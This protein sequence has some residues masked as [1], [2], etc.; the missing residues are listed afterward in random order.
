MAIDIPVLVDLLP[1]GVMAVD[2]GMRI[3][4]VNE[5]ACRLAHCKRGDLLGERC[6]DRLQP[7]DQDGKT[8]WAHG[9]H[10]SAYLRSVT[11]LPEQIVTI[12]CGDGRDASVR[13][14]GIYLRDTDGAPSGAVLCLRNA[15][16]HL[17]AGPSGIEIVSTISHELR[18][19]LTSLKGYT[20]LLLNRWGSMH[21]DQ[22]HVLLE[23]I[24]HDAARVTRLIN[25][26]LDA[27]RLECGRPVLH[28]Q[29]VDLPRLAASVVGKVHLEHPSMDAETVFPD[30]FPKLFID[31]DKVEQ[32]L[33]NLV[34][35]ACKYGSP[36]GLRVEG[37]DGDGFVSVAVIDRGEGIPAADLRQVFA[38]S[39]RRST[40]Q[41]TGSGLGLWISRGIVEA[42]GGRLVAESNPGT[43]STF[44]FTLPKIDLDRT[45]ES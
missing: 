33:I 34:E 3:T 7:R 14:T 36:R 20:G 11:R 16:V 12:R 41:P 44:R 32:V 15:A 30:S 45:K 2:R 21:N 27:S 37:A 10:R 9:W 4:A 18:S 25:E 23:Q 17:P 19:P 6:A 22:R 42:H 39:F 13:M 28:R 35:N 24:N 40:D 8:L 5:A 26:L 31:P 1:D 43:G 29:L 38:K